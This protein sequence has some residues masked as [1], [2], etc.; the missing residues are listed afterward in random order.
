MEVIMKISLKNCYGI[1][2]LKEQHFFQQRKSVEVLYSPNGTM[3]TSF[4]KALKDVSE[5][6]RPKD[7]IYPENTTSYDIELKG[8][9]YAHNQETDTEEPTDVPDI[10]VF[11][12]RAEHFTNVAFDKS[13]QNLLAD[14]EHK[15][16][17]QQHS[18]I[19]RTM[20]RDI[21]ENANKYVKE[22]RAENK[23]IL[24]LNGMLKTLE[25]DGVQNIDSNTNLELLESICEQILKIK[26]DN[27]IDESYV[28]YFIPT[29]ALIDV[30]DANKDGLLKYIELNKKLEEES[31][32]FSSDFSPTQGE[33]LVTQFKKNNFFKSHNAVLKTTQE[34]FEDDTSYETF[35]TNKKQEIFT[36]DEVQ[37]QYDILKKAFSSQTATKYF[38]LI[39]ESPEKIKR[40]VELGARQFNLNIIE[41]IC[42]Q[43][44]YN[45]ENI[46]GEYTSY[47]DE[48]KKVV[49]HAKSADTL[50]ES[51]VEEFNERFHLPYTIG[52]KNVEDAILKEKVPMLQF[53]KRGTDDQIIEK[54]Q[55]GTTLSQGEERAY[56]LL[57]IILEIEQLKKECN[58]DNK[59][60]LLVF[61]D[62]VDSFD[63]KNKYAIVEYL[64]EI[65]QN[66]CFK[67]MIL[68]HNYDFFR[69]IKGRIQAQGRFC[70]SDKG[71]LTFSKGDD[72]EILNTYRKSYK[73]QDGEMSVDKLIA[74]VPFMRN[75][76]EYLDFNSEKEELTKCLH[77][78]DKSTA[79]REV[80]N[81]F[82]TIFKINSA[83]YNTEKRNGELFIDVLFQSA[84]TR[85]T[86]PSGDLL[87]DKV[88]LSMAC[89][90]LLE[91]III[92]KCGL[93]KAQ[94]DGISSNQTRELTKFITTT[95]TELQKLAQRVNIVT[96]ESIHLNSFMIEPLLDLSIG[97][98]EILYKDLK[99]YAIQHLTNET[100]IDIDGLPKLSHHINCKS[101][102]KQLNQCNGLKII[103]EH[104]GVIKILPQI[105]QGMTMI[106]QD[107]L[108]ENNVEYEIIKFGEYPIL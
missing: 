79:M 22:L 72:K 38:E 50:W 93:T 28:N 75:I 12:S 65:S 76:A 45:F 81:I 58:L 2:E 89:R 101:K 26:Y 108:S 69:T 97:E 82:D 88:I 49:E 91:K 41:Y 9:T 44:T 25:L 73:D 29:T 6:K 59:E 84:D 100:R 64:L 23:E 62:I 107:I 86:H 43:G 92:E 17:L 37:K 87:T 34:A 90:L 21:N 3:K 95:D 42:G 53:F 96:P 8:I 7:I 104:D 66:T 98:F 71:V 54:E 51:V 94:M 14:N 70:M 5:G 68:T 52:I 55:I 74:M 83:A 13:I 4:A 10:K 33:T 85:K 105:F 18:E 63:Y 27:H 103:G 106:D 47:K 16:E 46:R 19:L 102:A 11:E 1:A 39:I 67:T 56:F 99:T 77:I 20:I 36:S 35:V 61:D 57:N 15:R 24:T 48:K 40:V 78:K 30:V 31:T 60:Y 80:Y 32:F